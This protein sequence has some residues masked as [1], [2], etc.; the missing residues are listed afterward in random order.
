M[1]N[2]PHFL[3]LSASRVYRLAM[4]MP[5]CAKYLPDFAQEKPINRNYLFN[6]SYLV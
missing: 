2:V 4:N 6:V 3:E 5:G 1:V